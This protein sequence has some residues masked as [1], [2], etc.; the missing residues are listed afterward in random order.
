M[1]KNNPQLNK[2][3]IIIDLIVAS[4][5][6]FLAWYLVIVIRAQRNQFITIPNEYY[7]FG[8]VCIVLFYI[9]MA[10]IGNIYGDTRSSGAIKVFTDIV[11]LNIIVFLSASAILFVYRKN[12]YVSIFST[13]IIVVFCSINV[14][15]Q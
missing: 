6:Y 15:L 1:F 14:V 13:L 9:V 2:L 7:V 12:P 10:V 4:A 5:A 11:R 3:L 8:G